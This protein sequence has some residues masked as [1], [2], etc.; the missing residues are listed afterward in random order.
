MLRIRQIKVPIDKDNQEFLYTAVSKMLKVK[1]EELSN[2]IITKKSLDARKKDNVHYV[3]EVDISISNEDKILKKNK[4]LDILKTPDERYIFTSSGTKEIINRP[5]IV[6][7]G[8]A[9][10]FCAYVLAENNYKPLVIERGESVEKR[11]EI[12]E[13]F[14][15]TG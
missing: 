1:R 4:S 13:H 10:L 14:W 2:L 11:V 7:S 5:I 8:P 9:G 12:I 15:K 6:G 3:Y